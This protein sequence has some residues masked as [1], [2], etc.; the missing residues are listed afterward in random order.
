MAHDGEGRR[1]LGTADYK[2]PPISAWKATWLL[3]RFNPGLFALDTLAYIFAGLFPIFLAFLTA[4]AFSILVGDGRFQLDFPSIIAL[5]VTVAVVGTAV[6]YG[7]HILDFYYAFSLTVLMRKNMMQRILE[8]PGAAATLTTP[9]EMVSR[10]AGDARNVRQLA[11]QALQIT[12]HVVVILVGL[13]I[14]V[15]LSP[16]ATVLVLLPLLFSIF[17]VN[18]VRK[19]IAQYRSAARGAEGDVTGFV[20]EMFGAVQAIKV[21]QAEG[22]VDG[23]FRKINE[24]RR[25][26]ALKDSLFQELLTVVMQN[27]N[28]L[29]IG[30]ILLLIAAQINAGGSQFTLAEFVL[31]TSLLLPVSTSLTFFGQTLAL[32]KTAAVS[33]K[34]M[35]D[36]LQGGPPERL[37]QPGP[38]Y[39]RRNSGWPDV[40]Y[41]EKTAVHHLQSFSLRHLTYKYPDTKRG[42]EDVSLTIPRGAFVVVTGRIGSGKTTLLRAAL[43]LLPAEGEWLWNGTPIPNL[44]DFLTPPRTAYTPQVPRLF[45]ESLGDNILQGIPP[46]KVDIQAAIESAVMEQDLLDLEEGLETMVGTR[47]VKLSGGQMQRTAAARMF[48]RQPELYLFDDLSS[49]LDVNTEQQLWE[50]LFQK[51]DVSTCLVVSHRKPALRRADHVMVL[52]NGRVCDEG[53]LDELLERC[54]EM[55]RLWAGDVGGAT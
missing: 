26:T 36:V 46:E 4:E 17:L 30:I 48:A 50:R 19:R 5:L 1:R 24:S 35:I 55:Q 23:R 47:G 28:S 44:A 54:T 14:M 11:L 27:T 33:L 42:I 18:A 10:F 52:Q 9:G 25:D 7:A 37:F 2:A 40:P 12:M 6:E 32:H 3:I 29:S 34:R 22:F 8:L 39:L 45:S 31:F 21:N 41:V 16:I 51:S 43:G 13:G 49:A 53:S 15:R 38:V 20:G